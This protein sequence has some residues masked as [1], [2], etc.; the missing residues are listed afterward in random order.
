[1][2]LRNRIL[3]DLEDIDS[4]N[5]SALWRQLFRR[6]SPGRIGSALRFA[7]LAQGMQ[8]KEFQQSR[9]I[10]R[11]LESAITDQSAPVERR[12]TRIGSRLVRGWGGINHEVIV[13]LKGFSYRG[14][15]YQSLS[16]IARLITGTR[17]SG[18]RFFGLNSKEAT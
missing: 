6:Q 17:W 8:E 5:C 15:V 16:E 3:E 4:T 18:P 9:L 11:Q 14:T 2:S 13:L 12:S 7:M 10:D 1:M